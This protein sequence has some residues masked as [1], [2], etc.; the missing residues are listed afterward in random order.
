MKK[1]S[2][3][4]LCSLLPIFSQMAF[5][6]A[7]PAARLSPG[8]EKILKS[9]VKP[10]SDSL[11]EILIILENSEFQKQLAVTSASNSITRAERIKSVTGQLQRF[12]SQGSD[13]VKRFL[14]ANA[15]G[16]VRNFWV[17]PAFSA[18]LSISK[19][20]ELAEFKGI[21]LIVE[22][23]ALSFE[24][25]VE[26]SPAPSLSTS[27]ST[28]LQMLNVPQLWSQGLT[29]RGRLICSFDT[30]VD[31][32]HPALAAKWRGHMSALSSAWFSMAEPNAL[33]N[34]N[35]GHGTHTMGVLIGSEGADTI[36][37]AFDAQ[38]ITAGVIDQG[39]PLSSTISDI[40]AAFQ[41]VLNPDGNNNTTDDVPDVILNSWGVPRGLFA[42][43]DA[44]FWTVIDNVEAAGIV[45]IF[46]A[47]NEGPGGKTMRSPAD[48]ATTP[49]NSF[50]VGAVDNNEVVGS[51]SS[52]GPSSCD[53]S[54]HKPEVVAPGVNIRSS[55]RGGGYG[56]M[57]GTSM[58]APF[59]AGLV[60][61]IR[62]FN[63]DATVEQIKN[64][65]ILSCDDLGPFGDDNAYGY[66]LPDAS[67]LLNFI[68][69]PSAAT[70]NVIN[71][72]ITENISPY[73]GDQFHLRLTLSKLNGNVNSISG[74]LRAVDLSEATV[75]VDRANF[76]FGGIGSSSI[77]IPD[78]EITFGEDLVHGQ[79]VDFCLELEDGAGN[80]FD[81]LFFSL[82]AGMAPLG[83][84]GN[85]LTNRIDFSVS[86]FGQFGF[87][88]NSIYNAGGLGFR[89]DGGANVLYE[90]GIIVG[91]N[92]LLLSSTIRDSLGNLNPSDFGVQQILKLGRDADGADYFSST[93]RDIYSSIMI[94]VTVVQKTRTYNMSGQYGYVILEFWLKNHTLENLTSMYFGFV[95]DFDMG[96]SGD[97]QQYEPSQKLAWTQNSAGQAVGIV[98]LQNVSGFSYQTNSSPKSGFTR[99]KQFELI[100][101]GNYSA[102]PSSDVDAMSIAKSGPFNIAPGDSLKIALALVIGSSTADLF[103][104]AQTAQAR[105][106]MSTDIGDESEII[107]TE[108]TLHQNYPN[109]FN[110]TTSISFALEKKQAI[111]LTINN[112]L[113]QEVKT[114]YS[115]T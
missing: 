34:D 101:T 37:V 65:I 86:D 50:A 84:I 16:E 11:V 92:Q 44:T 10:A 21:N 80:V 33:P 35:T 2:A 5:S 28:H 107:P 38:W 8:L 3:L 55:I 14:E 81:T 4:L 25:P 39:R 106:S 98:G 12:K 112:M 6:K 40:L 75:T 91:R 62:Q 111:K 97:N 103:G 73:P 76:F 89:F 93:M 71:Q 69:P 19:I 59:I 72:V 23:A 51:F 41:W 88:P 7:A 79:L 13:E 63:P 87:G 64:A 108:F 82:T 95:A 109:P 100:S 31:V 115:G 42:P 29:G 110:P 24:P 94:P 27:V 70:F 114:L 99:Q 104:N 22:N 61:L 77:G 32:G 49:L 54:Q 56:F 68:P 57:T 58:A 53:T 18:V 43:C 74:K 90:A 85:L 113:G 46:A 60:P 17:L 102:I 47:G 45:T 105:Y 30:G 9:P 48:R 36:G 78:F 67:R 1:W 26:S 15:V 20:E 96:L 52:R 66:G 83:T